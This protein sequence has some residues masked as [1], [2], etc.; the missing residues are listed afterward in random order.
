M[1]WFKLNRNYAILLYCAAFSVLAINIVVS[2]I[3]IMQQ[4]SFYGPLVEP[5]YTRSLVGNFALASAFAL[6]Y[7]L[8][9][10]TSFV[11]TWLATTLLLKHYSNKFGRYG[12]W[13]TVSLPLIY[14]LFEF[15][16]QFLKVFFYFGPL[17]IVVFGL[18]SVLFFTA[19]RQVGGIL[20]GIAFWSTGSKI[21]KERVANSLI[22]SGGG[23]ILLFSSNI[24]G[25]FILA[26]Y[27]PFGL[28]AF[29]FMG[30]ASYMMSVGIFES[31]VDVAKD[32]LLR[33]EIHKGV[34]NQLAFLKGIGFSEME[35]ELEKNIK[36]A[37]KYVIRTEK[38]LPRF[39]VE[40]EDIKEMIRDVLKE[41]HPN[42][43]ESTKNE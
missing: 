36:P 9:S 7:K 35:R 17:P 12:Y 22:I 10:G 23:M 6:P 34:G 29:S 26:P 20:F 21:S 37:L 11:L 15:Q 30:I 31:A 42:N 41:L 40:E 33:K 18:I 43:D 2:L 14:F 38:A 27:P 1:T 19:T 32:V 3:Y 25:G 5:L 16:P 24:L 39:D 13:I 28:I 4:F 8:I